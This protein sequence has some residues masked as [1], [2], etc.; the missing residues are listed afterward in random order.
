MG[1]EASKEFKDQLDQRETK[2][3]E[4]KLVH[5]ASVEP[6]VKKEILV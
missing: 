4:E 3:I 2:A 1:P 6:K 5:K